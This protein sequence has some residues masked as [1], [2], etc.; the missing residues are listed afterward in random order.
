MIFDYIKKYG[1]Y[2]FFEEEFNEVDNV[3]FSSLSYIEILDNIN[4]K[5]ENLYELIFIGNYKKKFNSSISEVKTALQILYLCAK[6]NRYR[7]VSIMNVE[8]VID[9]TTQFQVTSF[10]LEDSLVYASF[11]G[12]N[13]LLSGWEEDFNMTYSYPLKAQML[14]QKYLEKNYSKTNYD[15]IIGGH[16]KGGNLAVTSTFKINDELNKRI[17]RVYSNDGLGLMVQQYT[18]NEYK[19]VQDRVVSIIPD[20]SL[21]GLLLHNDNRIIIKTSKKIISSHNPSSWKVEDNHF[22][23]TNLSKFSLVFEKT[24]HM[25]LD[26]YNEE[27][28]KKFTTEIFDI[29]RKLNIE[30]LIDIKLKKKYLLKMIMESKNVDILVKIMVKDFIK[31]YKN[32]YTSYS[33]EVS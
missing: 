19:R 17:K 14:A 3:I 33:R 18:S 9:K 6:E 23:R 26:K 25:W 24:F 4:C 12:T 29:F 27:E 20:Y 1:K 15:L 31:T 5:L 21:V 28:K 11:S 32:N 22:V 13:H 30:S 7:D 8:K 10:L 16:S 2:T